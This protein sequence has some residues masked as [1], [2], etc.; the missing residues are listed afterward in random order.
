MQPKENHHHIHHH[1]AHG[2]HHGPADAGQMGTVYKA[3]IVLNL[4]FVAAEAAAGVIGNS[5]GLLSDA[6]HNLSDV[7]SLLLAMVAL[8]LSQTHATKRFTYGYRKSSVLISLLNA[9]ILLVAVG[10]IVVESIHKFA[11]PAPVNGQLVTWTAAAAIVVNGFTAWMLSRNQHDINSR[12]AFLHMLADTLV[13]AGVVVSGIVITH[14]GW[15]VIDP[16]IGLVVAAVILVSTWQLLSESLRLSVDAVPEGID[17]DAVVDKLK[18][19]E[20]VVN[21]H[22]LHI[23]PISTT[24]TALTAHVVIAD[25]NRLDDITY[26]LKEMLRTEGI[27]HSTL[28]LETPDSHCSGRCCGDSD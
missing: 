9:I 11:H 8:R 25:S 2:H 12:G 21:I 26:R 14:T 1:H 15:T 27:A 7:F 3:A 28:E 23:W 4:L 22:H 19:A 17:P 18:A 16:V 6:G 5:M 13:S 10:G 20:G 24:E